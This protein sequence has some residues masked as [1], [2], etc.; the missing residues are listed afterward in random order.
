MG[1]GNVSVAALQRTPRR[2][3]LASVDETL[4]DAKEHAWREVAAVDAAYA[5][6]DID[7]DGWHHAME[8]LIVPAYLSAPTPRGG[9]GHTGT[10]LDWERSRGVVAEAI[11]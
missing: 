5:R 3:K 10:E 8:E 4:E 2:R 6:G 9:S 7:D 11:D 1:S